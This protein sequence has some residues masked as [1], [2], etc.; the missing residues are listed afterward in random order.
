MFAQPLYHTLYETFELVDELFDIGFAFNTAVTQMWALMAVDLADIK[1]T[2]TAVDG[3]GP[4]ESVING[5][6]GIYTR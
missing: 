5:S 4:P 6:T 2:T 3:C 1:V